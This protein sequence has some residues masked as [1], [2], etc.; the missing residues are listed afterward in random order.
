MFAAF[1]ALLL[2]QEPQ[3]IRV[4]T[5][6]YATPAS[7]AIRVQSN[8][9]ELGVIVRNRKGEAVSGLKA[10]D[11]ELLDKGAPQKI[12]FFEERK[13]AQ[14]SNLRNEANTLIASPNI[15]GR[16]V[17][18]PSTLA[19]TARPPRTIALFFDDTHAGVMIGRS[20]A[21]AEKLINGLSPEVLVGIFTD[22]NTV[23]LSFTRDRKAL[24]EAIARITPHPLTGS[25]GFGE[26][27]VLTPY[28]AFVIDQHIDQDAR[29]MAIDEVVGCLC[30][31]PDAA[32]CHRIFAGFADTA[33][34]NV[35]N[36]FKFQ[37]VSTLDIVN[38]IVKALSSAPGERTLVVMSPGF[39]TG[40]MER[41]WSGIV[42]AAL[43]AHIVVSGLDTEGLIGSG[44]ESPES[45]GQDRGRRVA[46]AQKTLGQRQLVIT[47]WIATMA[48][49]TGGRFIVNNN[50]MAGALHD[51]TAQPEVSYR[52]AFA[53]SGAPDEKYHP[54]KV[55]LR[56]DRSDQLQFR[57]GYFSTPLKETAQQ[58]IDRKVAS[59]ET[60]DQIPA[61]VHAAREGSAVQVEIT[62]DA[63]HVPFAEKSGRHVQELTFV[64][65]VEDEK[66]AILQ[67]TETVMDLEL[68][69]ATLADLQSTGIRTNALFTLRTGSYTI[70]EVVREAVHDHFAAVNTKVEVP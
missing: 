34:A 32:E 38:Q 65:V 21:A 12:T 18:D 35:W 70:R 7:A 59:K 54:L 39:A 26:C 27:P 2:A 28:E 30:Q 68:T 57:P 47:E 58:R 1:L 16:G 50:D 40:G 4:R 11:F 8:L 51:L 25:H 36:Q 22:S 64:T 13:T 20:R 9:V 31:S 41:Q 60:L 62:V 19:E 5:G 49:A 33:A 53:P 43:R 23:Q 10:S 44:V 15:S 48:A 69:P 67:G 66:G 52:L 61:A 42:D 56:N 24:L 55:R 3:E 14:V 63:K 45:L 29:D 46:W 17:T 6:P 37:S